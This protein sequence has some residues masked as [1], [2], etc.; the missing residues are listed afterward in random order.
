MTITAYTFEDADG[1]EY[2]FITQNTAEA[3]EHARKHDL[4]C[5]ANEFELSGRS[6]AYDFLPQTDDES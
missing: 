6:V 1:L 5:Y 4:V 2:D 3:R